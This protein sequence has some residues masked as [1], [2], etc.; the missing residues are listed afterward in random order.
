MPDGSHDAVR[1]TDSLEGKDVCLEEPVIR[2]SFGAEDEMNHCHFEP[3]ARN[4]KFRFPAV[5]RG[6][7]WGCQSHGSRGSSPSK[8]TLLAPYPFLSVLADSNA[9]ASE[10]GD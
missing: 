7:G 3:K 10:I 9:A 4:L 1:N 6:R 2:L 5:P 8:M